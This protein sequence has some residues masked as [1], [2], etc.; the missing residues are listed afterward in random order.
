[1]SITSVSRRAGPPQV[2]QVVATNGDFGASIATSS[3]TRGT[4]LVYAANGSV[5]GAIQSAAG[6]GTVYAINGSITG[7]VAFTKIGSG[8]VALAGHN[9]H[10]G[11][12]TVEAGTLRLVA[13]NASVTGLVYRLDASRTNTFTTLADGSNVTSWADAEGS[14]FTFST[15]NDLNCPVYDSSMFGGRGGLRFGV[16]SS[17]GRM[18]GSAVTNAQTV[19]AVNMNR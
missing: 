10:T 4:D 7:N 15:T 11:T 16:G 6:I 19:F 12:T 5:T 1:L 2:G 9:T 18:I 17:R 13:G 14:G 3:T 8:A